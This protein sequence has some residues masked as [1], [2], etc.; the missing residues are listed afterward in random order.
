M[1]CFVL[2]RKGAL[3]AKAN[4]YTEGTFKKCDL[5]MHSSSCYSRPFKRDEFIAAILGSDLDAVAVTDHNSV[6]VPLLESLASQLSNSGIT[7]LAGV[8]LNI[9]LNEETIK[10]NDLKVAHGRAGHYFHA[11]VWCSMENA[12]ALCSRVDEL[13]AAGDEAVAALVAKV[14]SGMISRREYSKSIADQAVYLEDMQEKLAHIPHFFVPHENKGDRNLSDYLPVLDEN[15]SFIESNDAYKDSLFYY[16][17]AMAVEGGEK[18][19]KRISA[20]MARQRN[21]TIASLLFGDAKSLEEIGGKFTWIDFDGDLDSLLLAISDPDSRIVTSDVDDAL[22]QRNTANFLEAISFDMYSVNGEDRKKTRQTIM[23]SPGF[24]GIVG[25]RG[26][27][28]SLLAR[29][30]AK[31][32][33]S[34][35][36]SFVDISSIRFRKHG[37]IST[38]DVPKC[39]YLGQG[40]LEAVFKQEDYSQVPFLHDRIAPMIASANAESDKAFSELK[41]I[42]DLERRLLIAF[43]ERYPEG[44]VHFDHLD[45]ERPSGI[46]IAKP[47]EYPASDS[48]KLK[49]VQGDLSRSVSNLVEAKRSLTDTEL[50][51]TYPEDEELFH[52]LNVELQAVKADIESVL[53]RAARMSALLD[54]CDDKWFSA[55]EG[56]VELYDTTLNAFNGDSESYTLNEYNEHDDEA[57]SFFLDLLEVRRA[58]ADLD[59]AAS[60]AYTKMLTPVA[61]NVLKN[62]DDEISINLSFEADDEFEDHIDTL[63]SRFGRNKVQPLVFACLRQNEIQVAKS[64]FAANKFR[65]LPSQDVQGYL[66]KYFTQLE[67]AIRDARKPSQSISLNGIPLEDMSPGMK[68]EALLKLFL[69]DEIAEEN[70]VYVIL[71]QPE[72]NLDVATIKR[73]LIRRIKKMKLGLQFFVVSH[74]APV[75]VNGDARTVITCTNNDDSISYSYG[76]LNEPEVKQR[77]VDVLDGGERYLKMRLNKYNFKVG[78]KR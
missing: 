4:R 38:A 50:V 41:E 3:L 34:D 77:I 56:L 54:N 55:R 39:L 21:S 9:R 29:I 32:D 7:L 57:K 71:D 62:E 42:L 6:D 28:K 25:S 40:A 11:V 53:Q 45:S 70:Y 49:K 24:N 64:V 13:F 18:S 69:H 30:L 8:E 16:S 36:D 46:T 78:E 66:N 63:L 61:P 68:A 22:P 19:R 1:V 35:Y 10:Y 65:A 60:T 31:R 5:H 75:I 15:G 37:G 44:V 59:K 2:F 74:S 14:N 43:I 26:S 47:Q 52:P 51:A 27:G 72:D 20:N 33:L 73:F 76:A 58:L 23:F 67:T 48:G 12:S 17:H